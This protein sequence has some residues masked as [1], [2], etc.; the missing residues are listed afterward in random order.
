MKEASARFT[1]EVLDPSGSVE[2]AE[3]YAPR[4][5]SLSGKTICELSNHMWQ[6]QRIFPALRSLLQER[7]PDLKVIPYTELPNIYGLDSGALSRLL[8]EKG[9]DG[10]I[11]GNAA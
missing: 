6:D 9:C 8:K 1:L 10:A 5:P 3:D 11:V 4:L 7:F 2:I